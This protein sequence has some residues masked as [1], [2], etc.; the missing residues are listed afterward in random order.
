MTSVEY[1][2]RSL[3]DFLRELRLFVEIESPT[4]EVAQMER[5]AALY[6]EVSQSP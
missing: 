5:A 4:G 2:T 6:D 1:F 3:Q